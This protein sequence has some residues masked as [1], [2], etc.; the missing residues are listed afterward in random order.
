M[1]TAEQSEILQPTDTVG[2][3]VESGTAALAAAGIPTARLDAEVLL[4]HA[5]GVDRAA[6]YARWRSI[7]PR[8]L[9]IP[10]RHPGCPPAET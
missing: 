10:F 4:A 2:A 3:L 6:L 1:N 7:V 5:C 8:R 9:P